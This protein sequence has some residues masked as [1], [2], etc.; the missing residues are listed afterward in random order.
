MTRGTTPTLKFHIDDEIDMSRITSVYITL[1]Q[2]KTVLT[3][4]LDDITVE[5]EE[6]MLY[7]YLTQEDTLLF[8]DGYISV[9][10]RAIIDDSSAV[11]S[12]IAMIDMGHILKEGVIE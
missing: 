5:P 10:V 3:K 6:K 8:N 9:Q 2:R 1:K 4:T 7:C 11:A 12:K